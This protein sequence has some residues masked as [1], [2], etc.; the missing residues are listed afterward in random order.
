MLLEF[1]IIFWRQSI[2][3][4]INKQMFCTL[5]LKELPHNLLIDK[6]STSNVTR[7]LT[8]QHEFIIATIQS[9]KVSKSR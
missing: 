1:I 5:L 9:H 8:D 6:N 2:D 3:S 7:P 4:F